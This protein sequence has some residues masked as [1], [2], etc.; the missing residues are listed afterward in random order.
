MS[1][2]PAIIFPRRSKKNPYADRGLAEFERLSAELEAKRKKLLVQLG[3]P[4]SLVRFAIGSDETKWIPIIICPTL[5][6]EELRLIRQAALNLISDD[7]DVLNDGK[8]TRTGNAKSAASSFD[9]IHPSD[10]LKTGEDAHAN[11]TV[12]RKFTR[13]AL[14]AEKLLWMAAF[15]L[16]IVADIVLNA[17]GLKARPDITPQRRRPI[18]LRQE[19]VNKHITMATSVH[20]P[21]LLPPRV[22]PATMSGPLHIK[23]KGPSH[24]LH[25]K[26]P[27]GHYKPENLGCSTAPSTPTNSRQLKKPLLTFVSL[28]KTCGLEEEQGFTKQ[29]QLCTTAS[30][31]RMTTCLEESE[32]DSPRR[33]KTLTNK[34]A[35]TKGNAE[36]LGQA[37][38][39]A[40]VVLGLG[41]LV[42]GYFPAIVSIVCW[43]YLL[44]TLRKAVGD[45]PTIVKGHHHHQNRS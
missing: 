27:K 10:V 3:T 18:S 5:S 40:G 4:L 17:I 25:L 19:R 21:S 6:T 28:P 29:T 38:T 39:G 22:A 32:S 45:K 2:A 44:P 13:M 15:G 26:V 9:Q 8:S 14:A 24:P 43:W 16:S 37:L 41:G 23:A 36:K 34:Y 31:P 12:D 30:L 1:C 33:A 20:V 11:I 7:R 35:D 42:M